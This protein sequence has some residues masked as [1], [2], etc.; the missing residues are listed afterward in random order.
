MN[1]LEIPYNKFI[2]LRKSDKPTEFIL[3]LESKAEYINHLGTVHA[4]ALFALAEASSG[5]FLLDQFVVYNLPLIPVVRKVEVKFNKPANGVIYSKAAIIDSTT[6]TIVEELKEKKRVLL[7]IR[8]D[9]FNS[10]SEKVFTS[11]YDWFITMLN[12]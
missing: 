9:L 12:D 1:I 2:G 3:M 10:N 4:S 6:E 8:V 5:Q 7:K 11:V